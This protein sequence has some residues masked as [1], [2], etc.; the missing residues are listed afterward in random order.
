MMKPYLPPL[1]IV[2]IIMLKICWQSPCVKLFLYVLHFEAEEL[3]I[4]FSLIQ[5]STSSF[6]LFRVDKWLCMRIREWLRFQFTQQRNDRK[7]ITGRVCAF[8]VTSERV[9]A[10]DQN[11]CKRL[12]F[13][14][15]TDLPRYWHAMKDYLYS[16]TIKSFL[17]YTDAF[18]SLWRGK[19]IWFSIDFVEGN[20]PTTWV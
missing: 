12:I 10:I 7:V 16:T 13:L 11:V 17:R 18:I 2:I 3:F 20:L 19:S 5:I 4:F 14:L 6:G 8:S 15:H 1:L 9:Q